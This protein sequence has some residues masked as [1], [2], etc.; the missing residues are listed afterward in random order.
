MSTEKRK[1]LPQSLARKRSR[2]APEIV[3]YSVPEVCWLLGV[4]HNTVR[5]MVARGELKAERAGNLWRI[6]AD[7]FHRKYGPAIQELTT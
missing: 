6:L 5:S 1:E 4:S 7:D 2:K 3:G